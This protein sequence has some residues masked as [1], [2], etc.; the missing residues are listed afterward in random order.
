VGA[1]VTRTVN[2]LF[3]DLVGSTAQSHSLRPDDADE[4]R[5]VHLQLMQQAATDTGGTVVSPGGCA[6]GLSY[7]IA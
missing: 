4:L 1:A 2:V 6:V 5:R 7:A 3:T